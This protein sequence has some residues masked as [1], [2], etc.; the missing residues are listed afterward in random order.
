LQLLN[1]VSTLIEKINKLAKQKTPFF[2]FVDF[3]V[4]HP[5]LLTIE[6]LVNQDIRIVFPTFSN[7]NKVIGK[8][9]IRVEKNP[10][11]FEDYKSKFEIVKR[12]L[13]YGNSFLT[14]LTCETPISCASSLKE[15][16]DC[17]IA[18]YKI[19]FKD[20]WL[21]FSPETFIKIEDYK[22]SAYPM[23]GTID[24]SINNAEE[25]LLTD[26]KEIAEHYTIVDL[27]RNDLSRVSKNVEV[28]RF[29]YIDKIVS[30][31]KTL[32]QV[33]SHIEGV[34]PSNY[35]DDLG[36]LLFSL[37]PAGSISGAPKIKTL[38]IIQEAE[39]YDRGFYTGTAF[40]FDGINIDSCVLIRFIEQKKT[41]PRQ[42]LVYKSG[43]GITM[44]S[45]P[46][47]EYQELID[48]IYVPGF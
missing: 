41:T 5:V 48:K 14:N 15:L 37:L 33:S 12:N 16:Y 20:E 6:E 27:I 45:D 10:L 34:L 17:S 43:G 8:Q 24:G 40:Y 1:K 32:L 26:E 28:K 22:I 19:G 18:K 46:Q 3:L 39:Q 4:Q 2:L 23:K 21:C 44:Y 42:Q 25:I 36:T 7:S 47:K 38:E 11:S 35:L 13:Q 31:D 9:S 30:S 29:R